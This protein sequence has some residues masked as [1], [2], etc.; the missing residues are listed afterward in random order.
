[1]PQHLL[2]Q[3]VTIG[4]LMVRCW[5]ECCSNHTTYWVRSSDGDCSCDDAACPPA[6][7]CLYLSECI[8]EGYFNHT[9]S[10][11]RFLSG[12]HTF[13][14][15]P[16]PLILGADHLMLTG[17]LTTSTELPEIN[18]NDALGFIFYQT[19]N[20]TITNLKFNNCSQKIPRRLI[21]QKENNIQKQFYNN[22]FVGLFFSLTVNVKLANVHI[23]NSNGYGAM[24]WSPKGNFTVTNCSFVHNYWKQGTSRE[25]ISSTLIG[26]NAIF[27]F[28]NQRTKDA[29]VDIT[30]DNS[31][32]AYGIEQSGQKHGSGFSVVDE[33]TIKRVSVTLKNSRFHSNRAQNGS[34]L[35]IHSSRSNGTT[36][37]QI[38]N[39]TF[40]NGSSTRYGGAVYIFFDY[41]SNPPEKSELR[42]LL[43]YCT[44]VNNSAVEN[45]G[46]LYYEY[47]KAEIGL[48][49]ITDSVFKA[50]NASAISYFG[51]TSEKPKS[52]F[53][54]SFTV[55]RSNF[56]RNSASTFGGGGIHIYFTR[57]WAS[58]RCEESSFTGS[59]APMSGRG[60]AISVT[61]VGDL[62]KKKNVPTKELEFKSNSFTLSKGGP[63]EHKHCSTFY[64]ESANVTLINSNF[65]ENNCTGLHANG[66]TV[67]IKGTVHFR[68]NIAHTGGAIRLS[69]KLTYRRY[70]L[71]Q[72]IQSSLLNL[73]NTQVY[74]TGN[75]AMQFGGGISVDYCTPEL[76]YLK[77]TS[78]SSEVILQ[79]NTAVAGGHSVFEI[80]DCKS[81]T[82]SELSVRKIENKQR[83][84]EFAEQPIQIQFCKAGQNLT[85]TKT[86]DVLVYQGETFTVPIISTG[87]NCYAVKSV[88]LAEV[89][90]ECGRIEDTQVV[91]QLDNKCK[92]INY[93]LNTPC[94]YVKMQLTVLSTE[95]TSS[96]EPAILNINVREC[97]IGFVAEN[98][99]CKCET[100]LKSIG[101]RC[102][103]TTQ[104][105]TRPPATWIGVYSN[106][107]SRNGTMEIAAVHHHCP[108][109][110][111]K[112]KVYEMKLSN[113][114]TICA[115]N[116]VGIL[117]GSC[118]SG[119][120]LTL[121]ST[122]CSNTCTTVFLFLVIPFALA[123]VILVLLL[124]KCNLTVSTGTINGLIF[125]VNIVRANHAAFFSTQSAYKALT[126]TLG[127]LN[128]WLNLDFGIST[129]FYKGMTAIGNTWLQFLFPLYIWVLVG[130]LIVL[131]RY[132]TR[133]S[134]FTGSNTVSV[135]ATLFLLSY[136]KILRSLIAAVSFTWLSLPNRESEARWIMDGNIR[137]FEW[138]HNAL[139]GASV[140]ITLLLVIPF[141]LLV[142]LSPCLQ[143]APNNVTSRWV[144]KIKPILDT[145]QGPYNTQFRYW[146]GLLLLVRILLF[147][148]F[149]VSST[150]DPRV[151]M[152]AILVTVTALLV[153]WIL[154]TTKYGCGIYRDIWVERMELFFFLNLALF[155]AGT[156]FLASDYL[157]YFSPDKQAVLTL[158][159]VGSALAVSS[160][161]HYYKLLKRFTICT[162]LATVITK[163]FRRRFS[164]EHRSSTP[165]EV[166]TS[167]EEE[168]VDS[169]QETQQ[170][171]RHA[172]TTSE[173]T[174][175]DLREPLLNQS[176]TGDI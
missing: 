144:N 49:M 121:G 136:A 67:T 2:V 172:Y 129:C 80:T 58:V 65:T 159:M 20:I 146:T 105:I 135:L 89:Q 115:A 156:I 140:V 158:C 43:T 18:C 61:G 112:E 63:D 139:Y 54:M 166:V 79:D 109:D 114:S 133:L 29:D 141:T 8:E 116:R 94:P 59:T 55:S 82:E 161:Y 70:S 69:R 91:Q 163:C 118:K 111:C 93:T 134:K 57:Y 30:I 53:N 83:Q 62:K 174:L 101:A 95:I 6:N 73:N 122:G 149:A 39:C 99:R 37:I 4:L 50:N 71:Q 51:Q 171:Q 22:S 127:V 46:G 98:G 17:T 128:A 130:L 165:Q 74:I 157:K 143:K 75:S 35:L 28:N 78:N 66:S 151:N 147:I 175:C 3:V 153:Y 32:F 7:H 155:A 76:C 103:I 42:I 38:H 60:A 104:T 119:Y 16:T 126:D 124:L 86:H 84:S 14:G 110:Y 106:N 77:D 21:R 41:T 27:L 107:T 5:V 15:P 117:C 81:C 92:N 90:G 170:Q 24:V 152:L 31:E 113:P 45:G 150:G 23:S 68:N 9:C 169:P 36:D 48:L 10:E 44:V 47:Q 26:G 173:V 33:K 19:M 176:Y 154:M 160:V 138:P 72:V 64:L 131:S 167:Q 125:Y 40:S 96:N 52:Y 12:K 11:F 25:N 1:M 56:T 132:S 137:Y 13:K 168:T 120:S 162:T 142:L 108:F 102:D 123:G 87:L 145:Y 100:N 34:N 97:P 85:C 88:V 164:S 148:A